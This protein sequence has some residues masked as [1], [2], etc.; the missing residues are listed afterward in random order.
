MSSKETRKLAAQ[1][2]RPPQLRA[3]MG[4]VD[5]VNGDGTV[6]IYLGGDDVLI[7]NV[8]TIATVAVDDTVL[9]LQQAGDLWVL[10][11]KA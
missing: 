8:V 4:T 7:T 1:I 6:D 9:L 3:R 5:A 11:A 10:G 2:S